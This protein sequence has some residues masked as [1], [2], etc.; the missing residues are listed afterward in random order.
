MGVPQLLILATRRTDRNDRLLL[1][2][3]L[4]LMM[5]MTFLLIMLVLGVELCVPLCSFCFFCLAAWLLVPYVHA[6]TC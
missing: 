2:L 1:L 4:L 5:M 6:W 3:L